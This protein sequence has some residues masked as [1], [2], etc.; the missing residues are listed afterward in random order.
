MFDRLN[1]IN[2]LVTYLLWVDDA[3]NVQPLD[4]AVALALRRFRA[5]AGDRLLLIGDEGVVVTV[6]VAGTASDDLV[7]LKLDINIFD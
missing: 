2:F 4:Q 3:L 5:W 6:V 7:K 1:E